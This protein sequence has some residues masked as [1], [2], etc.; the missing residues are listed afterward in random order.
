MNHIRLTVTNLF[1]ENNIMS[2]D[3]KNTT[4]VFNVVPKS[5]TQVKCTVI[6]LCGLE[7]GKLCDDVLEIDTPPDVVKN[8]GQ[9]TM[10]FGTFSKYTI[11]GK[12]CQCNVTGNFLVQTNKLPVYY[13]TMMYDKQF[14]T[15]CLFNVFLYFTIDPESQAKLTSPEKYVNTLINGTFTLE[16]VPLDNDFSDEVKPFVTDEILKKYAS[17]F[18]SENQLQIISTVQQEVRAK[19]DQINNFFKPIPYD[20]LINKKYVFSALSKICNDSLM[21]ELMVYCIKLREKKRVE[22]QCPDSAFEAPTN[23][24]N[25]Q[26]IKQ[27]PEKLDELLNKNQE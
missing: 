19:L 4:P 25:L 20:D 7:E 15:G 8:I 13:I 24:I 23:V 18:N 1:I 17:I 16:C 6:G 26:E 3:Y 10:F 22:E 2:E 9:N 12:F 21:K 14:V 27:N 5:E 11:F